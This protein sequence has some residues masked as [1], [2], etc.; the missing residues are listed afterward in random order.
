[1]GSARAVNHAQGSDGVAGCGSER[2]TSATGTFRL[3]T[4]AQGSG[5]VRRGLTVFEPSGFD[6]LAISEEPGSAKVV[7]G[8]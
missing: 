5:G 6:K 1:M 8:H 7:T 3:G 4:L 2:G